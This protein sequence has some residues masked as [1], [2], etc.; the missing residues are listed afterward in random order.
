M[1][2]DPRLWHVRVTVAGT[3]MEPLIVRAAMQRFSDE[4]PFLA[5]V[6]FN[7]A[8]AEICYWDEGLAL[9]D[10]ASLALRVW[11]EH[12]DSARLP[13]WEVVGLEV[14]ERE[15]Q[16]GLHDSLLELNVQPLPF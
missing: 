14:V 2:E 13:D 10:V 7:A 4:R 12:R 6:R 11:S 8:R 3:P 5:S 9:V 1:I 16:L 15:M